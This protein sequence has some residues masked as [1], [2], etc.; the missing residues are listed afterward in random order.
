MINEPPFG[1]PP[2]AVEKIRGV[3]ACHPQVERAVLYGSRAK[4][5]YKNGSDI[6]L[7]LYGDALDLSLLLKI[8]GELDDL[9]L[10]WM[11][12]VSIYKQI[13][14]ESLREHIERVGI[15]FYEKKNG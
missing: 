7:T 3:F 1:L 12:D 4:G 11:F 9:L 14:N 2:A 6:D 5:N 15:T 10:P 13:D 8:L